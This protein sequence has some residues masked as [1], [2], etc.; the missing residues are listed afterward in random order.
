MLG[1]VWFTVS[2]RQESSQQGVQTMTGKLKKNIEIALGAVAVIWLVYLIELILP[3][4][5]KMYGIRPRSIVGL[6]GIAISPFLHAGFA[7][8]I[9]NTGALAIL[10]ILSLSYSRKLTFE[11]LAFVW[12]AG[13]G[14]VWIFGS[15]RSIHI[16]A[17]G[18]IFGMIGF[19]LFLG[20]FRREWKTIVISLVVLVFYGGTILSMLV[21]VP[22][23]SWAGHFFGFC[24]GVLAAWLARPDEE[25]NARRSARR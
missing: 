13:G 16:G 12:L 22:G 2:S 18:I 25:E 19:L 17:S 10:L 14:M 6:W 3:F 15:A 20:V 11:A 1:N 24:A 4:D 9:A 21:Y 8:L 23:V 5:L 7:H